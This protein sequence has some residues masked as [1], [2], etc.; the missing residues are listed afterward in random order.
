MTR[1]QLLPFLERLKRGVILADGAMGTMLHQSGAPMDTCFDALNLTAPER[2]QAVHLAYIEAGAELIETNTFGANRFKLAL[3]NRASEVAAINH[4]GVALA[5]AAVGEKPV[6]I[7][8]SVGPLGVRLA[9]YGRVSAEQAFEAFYEQ[10]A[11]LILGGVDLILLETFTDLAEIA[12]AVRAARAAN[13]N[14][15]VVASVTLTRDSTTI[16]GDP[17]REIA[18][19]LAETGAD[20]IGV[21]CSSGPSQLTRVAQVLRA[22]QPDLPILVMPNAGY[23]ETVNGRVMYPATPDYFGDYAVTLRSIGVNIIGGCC[24]TTPEHIRAMRAALDAPDRAPRIVVTSTESSA[25]SSDVAQEAPTRLA[26]K[27]AAGKFVT[28]VEMAP[29]RSFNA[30]KVLASAQML[31]EAGV[32]CIDVSDSPMARMRMSPWA[33][34]H[35]IQDRLGMETILH[36]PTRG[37]NILRV[38][39][40]LLAAHALNVRNI[41]VLMGDPTSIGDYPEANDKYDIV[42]SGL[43][44]LI[45][46]NLNSGRDQAGNS[47]GQPTAFTVGC[48]L[49]LT[50]QDIDDEIEKLRKKIEAGADF[51]MTQ[52]V[53]EPRKVE[54]FL[55]RYEELYGTLTLPILV[56]ILPLYGIRHATFLNNEVPGIS[57]P[58]SIMARMSAAGDVAPAVGVQIA[59]EILRDLRGMVQGA[60]IIPPFGKYEMAA[61]IVEALAQP[62]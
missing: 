31:Q 23:P 17:P 39:G 48:A 6:Y 61:E 40:D 4:A 15:P 55:R 22:A 24:G 58:E 59:A 53:Y 56:G 16:Y 41:L 26:Q 37:R 21:N 30:Q 9:P 45:K 28:T 2:V 12:E 13:P 20:V 36:F 52:S 42:P 60:Y 7:A 18:R 50:P 19:A 38:Q 33:V 29:P 11:A 34:C 1:S 5:R 57:I 49:N 47:I 32:D 3:H 27:L 10:I 25:L 54:Q 44:R 14:V 43:I 35:L 51:A 8:G 62:A 46:H